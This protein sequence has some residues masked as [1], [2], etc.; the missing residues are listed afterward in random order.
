ME[1]SRPVPGAGSV[2]QY[3]GFSKGTSF[4]ELCWHQWQNGENSWDYVLS[5]LEGRS[6]PDN[7]PYRVGLLKARERWRIIKT[8]HALLSKLARLEL[9]PGQVQ[10]IANPDQRAASGIDATEKDL[11]ANPY[12]LSECDLG[13]A[14]SDPVALETVDHGL[15]P[16]GDAA[17]FPDAD[18]I[19][20]DD[21]VGFGRLVLRFSRSRK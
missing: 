19:S 21:G 14:D 8:R 2:L 18:E 13:S 11:V 15:R 1:R 17:V 3:L 9:T 4:S 12:I 5:I 20:H 7:G 16:E 10:R 6:E